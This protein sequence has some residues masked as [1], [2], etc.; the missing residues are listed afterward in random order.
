[1]T[2][3]SKKIFIIG[4]TGAQEL[5]KDNA[6]SVRILTRNPSSKRAQDLA[7]LPNVELQE[8]RLDNDEELRRGFQGCLGAFVN[9][10]GFVIGQK[11]EIFWGIRS[12]QLAQEAGI[13]FFVWGNLDY[14][15][16]E[17]DYDP[18]HRCGHYDA[19]GAVGE[20]ILAQ[21][22]WHAERAHMAPSREKTSMG[23][24]LFTTRPYLDMALS[25]FTPMAPKIAKDGV[26]EWRIPLNTGAVVHIA[27]EECGKYVRWLFDH[28][29]TRDG[30]P[31]R[32][33]GMNLAV[34]TEH[35]K[36]EDVAAAFTKVTGHPARFVNVSEEEYWAAFP[37]GMLSRQ[38]GKEYSGMQETDGSLMTF[39]ENFRGFWRMWQA[40]GGEEPLIKRDYK[41]LDE[42]L[43]DRIKTVGEWIERNREMAMAVVE[44]KAGMILKIHEDRA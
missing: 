17:A 33:N 38:I 32:S 31:G 23:A 29:F 16:R 11:N 2:A 39:Q 42:I 22:Q 41:L 15:L 30:L 12:Y 44:G 14:V 19:K 27:L 18:Q 8:G 35:V 25:K 5:V 43:P 37:S 21:N 9:L 10:D 4:G 20:L 26:V 13:K 6:Y 24:A 28:A 36:Y 40:C 3:P 34:A 7:T 1:M